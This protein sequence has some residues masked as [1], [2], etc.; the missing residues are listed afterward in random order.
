MKLYDTTKALAVSP[1]KAAEILGC[2]RTRIYHLLHLGELISYRDG[3]ARRVLTSSI[4]DYVQRQ[5]E[6][7]A[8]CPQWSSTTKATE[9][10]KSKRD[11][12]GT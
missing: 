9:A 10:R 6:A 11:L 8:H 5:I 2:G 3:A 1:G 7:Q 12:K 4:H